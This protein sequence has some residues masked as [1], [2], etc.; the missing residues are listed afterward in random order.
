MPARIEKAE[1][2]YTAESL[3]RRIASERLTFFLSTITVEEAYRS[4]DGAAEFFPYNGFEPGDVTHVRIG[5]PASELDAEN[6]EYIPR[7]S[8]Y[9][10]RCAFTSVD[11]T[12][13]ATGTTT[14]CGDEHVMNCTCVFAVGTG[15]DGVLRSFATHL[16]PMVF[17]KGQQEEFSEILAERC[18]TLAGMSQPGSVGVAVAGGRPWYP[19]RLSNNEY[20][21][22]LAAIVPVVQ[23]NAQ[24]NPCIVWSPNAIG[25]STQAY[26]DTEERRLFVRRVVLRLPKPSLLT[27]R[28]KNANDDFKIL[29]YGQDKLPRRPR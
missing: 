17:L 28:G 11:A 13:K 6:I 27:P 16:D 20:E 3:S 14:L 19:S 8:E 2:G 18:S 5:A 9:F 29:R 10:H 24:T 26:L 4:P 25:D 21:R 12:H 1:G 22:S 7:T 15:H 23:K